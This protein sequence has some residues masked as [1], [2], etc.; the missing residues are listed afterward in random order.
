M[1]NNNTWKMAVEHYKQ[2]LEELRATYLTLKGSGILDDEEPMLYLAQ[3]L[4]EIM[5]GGQVVK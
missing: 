2:Q 1:D 4:I 5:W 3:G